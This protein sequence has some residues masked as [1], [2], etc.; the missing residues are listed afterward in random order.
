M[1]NLK[2]YLVVFKNGDVKRPMPSMSD[3]GV[4]MVKFSDIKDILKP[5]HNTSIR[6]LLCQY[7]SDIDN[8]RLRIDVSSDWY[9]DLVETL[10]QLPE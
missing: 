2:K 5:S 3:E 6:K 4:E 7:K 9:K 10:A 8:G 1:K